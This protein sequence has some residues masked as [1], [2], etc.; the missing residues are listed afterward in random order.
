MSAVK[1]LALITTWMGADSALSNCS[2][3]KCEK[4]VGMGLC[5]ALY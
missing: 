5:L 4:D 2:V 1:L 3:K